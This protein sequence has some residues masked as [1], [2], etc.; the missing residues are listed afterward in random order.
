MHL[1]RI[2][3]CQLES[4]PAL[5]TSHTN[6][7][8]E[9][10][11]PDNLDQSLS[12]LALKGIRTDNLQLLCYEK[13]V[14]WIEARI[15]TVLRT[16]E[17]FDPVPDLILWP[18]A[19]L[20]I[21]TLGAISE[22]SANS[23][24]TILAGTHTP[25]KTKEATIQYKNI[26]ISQK[27][28]NQ[29]FKKGSR[30]VLPII[31]QG[32]TKLIEKQQISPFEQSVVSQHSS[33]P[34]RPREYPIP[35]RQNKVL[36]L[37]IIC[38][39]A[40]VNLQL[41]RAYDVVGLISYDTQPEQFKNFVE[42]QIR[43]RKIVAYCNDGRYGGSM[44]H[45]VDDSRNSNWLRDA[46]PEGLP[47]GDS[48]LVVDVDLD[49]TTIQVGT[50][51]P[52]PAMRLVRLCSIVSDTSPEFE[53]SKTLAGIRELNSPEA[54][55]QELKLI[56]KS[57]D[58]TQLQK[59][60]Y[61]QL[62]QQESRGA[63]A[64][65]WWDAIGKDIVSEGVP[66]LATLEATLAASCSKYLIETE[67]PQ[68][69]QLGMKDNNISQNILAFIGKCQQRAKKTHP[70]EVRDPFSSIKPIINRETEANKVYHFLDSQSEVVLE[71]SG[72]SQI[73]K[74]SVIQKAI[75][76]SG[77]SSIKNILLSETT[78][79]DYVL[80]SLIKSNSTAN[81][82][83]YRNPVEIARS[84]QMARVFRQLDMLCLEKVHFL[85]DHGLWRDKNTTKV[86]NALCQLARENKTKLILET[87]R[88]LPLE[89]EDPSIRQRLRVSGLDR[90]FG[91]TLF[92][93]QLRRIGLSGTDITK[94]NR[95]TIVSKMAGHPVALAMAADAVYEAGVESVVS[96]LKKRKGFFLNFIS[97]LVKE[98]KLTNEEQLVAQLFCL[99]RGALPREAIIEASQISSI[100]PI[101]NLLGLGALEIGR[102]G[103]LQIADILRD[104]FNTADL[105]PETIS[106][107][108]KAAS[109][110]FGN[111]YQTNNNLALAIEADYHAGLAGI[112]SPVKT[113]LVDG[114][115]GTAKQL[116]Q[117]QQYNR[118][119]EIINSLLLQQRSR[120]IL[121]LAA[122][123]AARRNKFEDALALAR[124][125]FIDNRKD[126]W[127]LSELAKIALTQSQENIAEELVE[128]ARAAH[129]EDVSILIVEGRMFLRRQEI[130]KAEQVFSRAKQL[131]V[132]NPWPF[133]YLGR[134]YIA[135]DRLEDAIDVLYEGEQFIYELPSRNIRVL[136]AIKTQLGLT[137]LFQGYIDLAGQIIDP[138]FQD[139]P[140]SPEII[141]AYAALTIKREGISE[142]HKALKQLEKARIRTRHDR[143]Q[144]HLLYGL[145]YLG[146]DDKEN[147]SQQFAK[148]HS[149][150]RQN[151]FV[152]INWAQTL[153]ELAEELWIDGSS[154]YKEF[155]NNCA[156]LTRKILEFNRD[157]VRGIQLMENLHRTFNLDL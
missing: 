114:A 16:L 138:L 13:Y 20:P 8:E 30:N 6:F 4:H 157:N 96:D 70:V 100:H 44:V 19:S 35:H 84:E 99:A 98:F 129:V 151:V 3:L 56:L 86:L 18:E 94:N 141:R 46:F 58:A 80:Y 130:A 108:H 83:P 119:G 127:L 64:D 102:H 39:E 57:S 85:L 113:N 104:H 40:L 53:V 26:G 60:C 12:S 88:E 89:L 117:K 116:Y 154:E 31:I 140:N 79:L 131:T 65:D 49:V 14:D 109:I 10:F 93:A 21:S 87:Q 95:D 69:T 90:D 78:S 144:F 105:L 67:I 47:P 123:I 1:I 74:T 11:V 150:D 137:Y 72:L 7:L 27:R 63:P 149:S 128:I 103:H 97:T 61:D 52:R 91:A 38:A 71:V 28:L 34:P 73:G 107:F 155:V 2:A 54:K 110:T 125:V 143:C 134:T 118:A 59:I 133:F 122:L 111:S 121:R 55:A 33:K 81:L 15:A 45:T 145:F 68:V 5:Y 146:I 135:L 41:P 62:Y 25:L 9:P 156:S 22:W 115:L 101:R 82:P 75:Q 23:G 148:A 43:N 106:R 152:M 51:S 66:S 124:E 142:A 132:R 136:K 32:K 29:L 24:A 77:L 17:E 50:A 126:T 112:T 92:N 153:F 76:Q 36:L 48:I 42:T 147:A 120:D 37:P 139:N